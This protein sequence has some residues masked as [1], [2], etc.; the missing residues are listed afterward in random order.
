[1]AWAGENHKILYARADKIAAF[2]IECVCESE[3]FAGFN[4]GIGRA[5]KLNSLGLEFYKQNA[6]QKSENQIFFHI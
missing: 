2:G 5:S 1:L 4:N 6:E 3:L